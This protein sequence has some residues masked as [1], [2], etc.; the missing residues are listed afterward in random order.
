MLKKE[1]KPVLTTE[2]FS[3][4]NSKHIIEFLNTLDYVGLLKY[5][6]GN[7][8]GQLKY[9]SSKSFGVK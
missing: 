1:S 4:S 2:E 7:W 6:I 5:L 9:T 3:K 8:G